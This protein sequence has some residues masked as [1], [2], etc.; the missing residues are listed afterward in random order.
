MLATT[1][2]TR[3]D[4]QELVSHIC[5]RAFGIEQTTSLPQRGLRLAEEAIEAA[6]RC[7]TPAEM[8]HRLIDHVYG[9]PP[10]DLS[11]EL[12]GVSVTLLALAAAAGLS[13]DT[14]EQRE[15]ARLFSMPVEHFTE[16]NRAK[17]ALGFNATEPEQQI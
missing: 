17:N 12:G 5:R 6:Q 14:E 9:K 1:I 13:A 15:I 7:G 4:R 3:N 16:R 11:Q 10:G 2:K 8:L